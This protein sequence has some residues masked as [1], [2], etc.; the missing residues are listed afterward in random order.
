MPH[1]MSRA[2]LFVLAV[3]VA[4]SSL[5]GA[6]IVVPALPLEWIQRGPFTD[7]TI[8]AIALGFV[9]ILAIASAIS[10]IIRPE[11]A[12]LLAVVAGAAMVAFE[13][14][15]I[16]VVG[17]SIVVHGA[18]EPVAWLQIVY[19]VI[20]MAQMAVGFALWRATTP[21]RERWMRT[22][23]HLLGTHS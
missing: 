10:L 17:L 14:V 7:Y 11:V 20:G 23:H 21:D 15:E 4:L 22:G 19:I 18:D 9:G 3:F 6:A 1:V 8:P 5:F 16:T 13:L 2:L 12:G